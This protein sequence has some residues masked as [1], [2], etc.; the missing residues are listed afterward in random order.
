MNISR[1]SYSSSILPMTSTHLDAAPNSRVVATIEVP[2]HRLDD[3]TQSMGIAPQSTLLKIDT[4]GYESQAIRGAERLMVDIAA[5]QLELSM[6][7]LYEGQDLFDDLRRMMAD[8]GL[9]LFSIEP[10]I[11]DEQGRM[12][13][14]DG[15][16]IREALLPTAGEP[17]V[18]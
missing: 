3:L 14:C 15:L 11:A 12:L 17:V 8:Y 16:F 18:A 7:N 9:D 1:N 13:Q 10:G 6:V 4:Q 5:V 2:I